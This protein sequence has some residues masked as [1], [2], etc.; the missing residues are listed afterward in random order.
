MPVPA[1]VI[2][3]RGRLGVKGVS[4]ARCRILEGSEAGRIITRNVVGPLKEG[5]VIMLKETAIDSAGAMGR[6]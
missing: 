3:I 2:Q 6:K 1:E 4:A 5:D